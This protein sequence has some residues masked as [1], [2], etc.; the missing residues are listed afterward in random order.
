VLAGRD[1]EDLSSVRDGVI[2]LND[3]TVLYAQNTVYI[4]IAAWYEAVAGLPG[5]DGQLPVVPWDEDIA[6]IAVGILKSLDPGR[7]QFLRQPTLPCTE[8]AFHAAP[9][10][11]TVTWDVLYTQ[12]I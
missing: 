10:F 1:L 7:S 12:P 2:V 9:G 6:D 4:H 11:W 5:S 3:A 8:K